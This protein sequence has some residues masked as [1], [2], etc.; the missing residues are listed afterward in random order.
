M[1]VQAVPGLPYNTESGF[2]NTM[3]PTM[4]KMDSAGL[5]DT[6][7]RLWVRFQN[8][9]KDVLI[10][11]TTRDVRAGTTQYS[12]TSAR[13][14]LTVADSSG[15]G[16]LTPVRAS[17]NGLAQIPVVNGVAT[18]TWEVV[19]ANPVTLQDISFGVAVSAQTANPGQGLVS[20]AAG[21]GPVAL[22]R[23][24]FGRSPHSCTAEPRFPH[25]LSR[26]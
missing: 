5:A 15:N 23:I 3:F 21:L 2:L 14:V 24:L 8:I 20:I 26:I 4:M 18:A 16:Q 25:L 19:S 9:P 7:T 1:T 17:I 11:V 12:E 13:A 10:W 6:G 22:S